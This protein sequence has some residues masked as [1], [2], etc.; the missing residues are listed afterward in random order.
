MA[1]LWISHEMPRP[2]IGSQSQWLLVGSRGMIE[3]DSYGK[4][5][6]TR[7]GAWEQ[8]FEMPWFDLNADV[9]SPIRL[10]GFAAQVQD[11]VDAIAEDREPVVTGADGR[12]AVELVEATARSSQTGEAVRLPLAPAG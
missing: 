5:R 9:Y 7:E 1:H 8:A 2:G 4:V 12:A 10:K 11:L 3:S 6:V